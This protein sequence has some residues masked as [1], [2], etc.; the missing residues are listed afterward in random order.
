MCALREALFRPSF[1]VKRPVLADRTDDSFDFHPLAILLTRSQIPVG[2]RP[3]QRQR[4]FLKHLQLSRHHEGVKL[5]ASVTPRF[6]PGDPPARKTG[7]AAADKNPSRLVLHKEHLPRAVVVGHDAAQAHRILAV[8][9]FDGEFPDLLRAVSG[10]FSSPGGSAAAEATA[11]PHSTEQR[12]SQV[13]NP[14]DPS[15]FDP[16]LPAFQ[17]L[18][19]RKDFLAWRK[20]ADILVGPNRAPTSRLAG[21]CV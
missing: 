1:K 11:I 15:I 8:R 5:P 16:A 13:R 7:P 20:S 3:G 4:G 14:A 10:Q 2:N 12:P 18:A 19:G 9:L 21:V 17:I 6:R